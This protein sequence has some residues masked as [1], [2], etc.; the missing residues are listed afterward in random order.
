MAAA[1]EEMDQ[2]RQ[3]SD[4][5]FEEKMKVE[6]VVDEKDDKIQQLEKEL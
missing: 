1:T 5:M 3:K 4:D 6:K 2:I